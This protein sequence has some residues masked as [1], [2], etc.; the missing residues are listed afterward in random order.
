MYRIIC[1]TDGNVYPLLD[2]R[3]EAYTLQE[4]KLTL[5]LNK[6]GSLTFYMNIKHP[7]YGCIKKITSIISVYLVRRNG[8]EKWIYSGRSLT[9]E[10]DFYRTGKIEC[11]GILALLLDS[12]VRDYE[13]TGSPEE[14]FKYMITKHNEHVGKEKQFQFG[15][16]D[17]EGIDNN[18]IIIRSSTQKP[19]T[20]SEINTKIVESL[21]CY[22]SAKNNNGTYYID[23]TKD[24]EDSNS[25]EI[26]YGVNLIDLKKTVTASTLRTVMIGIGAEDKNGNKITVEVEDKDAIAEYGRIEGTVQFDDVTLEDNLLTK[27]TDYLQQCTGYNKTIEATAVGLNIID[28]EIQEI[29][30]GYINVYSEPHGLAERMLIS[31]MEL[32]LMSPEKNKYTLGISQNVYRDISET[33]KSVNTIDVRS[34][35]LQETVEKMKKQVAMLAQYTIGSATAA[36]TV[37]VASN[38]I[39]TLRVYKISTGQLMGVYQYVYA[40]NVYGTADTYAGKLSALTSALSNTYGTIAVNTTEKAVKVSSVKAY[41]IMI[42]VVTCMQER[43]E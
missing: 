40:N 7:N 3:D 32:N 31:K 13:F 35:S 28:E 18:E 21:G 9:D 26:R 10:E 29:S 22:V 14:Y 38:G 25:Q 6:T 41:Q 43:E 19:N 12:I 5:E 11:E 36:D 17:M 24:A 4:P 2:L 30:L 37:Y 39:I 27:T 16:I 33:N 15:T 1:E 34:S 20:L 23:C 42:D 8:S